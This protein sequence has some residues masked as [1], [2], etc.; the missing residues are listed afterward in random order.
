MGIINC[1]PDSFF[2]SSRAAVIEDAVEKAR[3]MI[4]QGADILDIGGE[5]SRPG[6]DYIS[7]EE[8][9]LR[10]VPAVEAIRKFSHIPVS[11][12]TRKADVARQA[13][14]AG[15]DIINDISALE[16]DESLGS[17]VAAAGAWIVLMHKRGQP[18]SM[19]E[20]PSYKDPLIEINNELAAAVDRAKSAG[21]PAD[22]I[23][24]D[25]G[26]GFGKRHIDNLLILQK[27][28]FFKKAGY[29]VLIGHSRKSFL[30]KITGRQVTER[31]AGSIAAGVLAQ[32]HGADILRVH[33]V[34]ETRDAILVTDAISGGI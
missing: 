28:S 32:I 18:D 10:V 26:I 25:P 4:K 3:A 13:L 16:D 31:L 21:I 7:E 23:I 6:S 27:T 19:Q 17:V 22:K 24:L 1:T 30:E 34:A 33:D 9:L 11:I 20:N 14:L 8:E 5:S 29:P 12:D 2:P 15:A